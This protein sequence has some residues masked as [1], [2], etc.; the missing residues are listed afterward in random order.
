M[1]PAR[2]ISW[3]LEELGARAAIAEERDR[4]ADERMDRLEKKIDQMLQA[5]A[6]GKG[7]WWAITKLGGI[8]VM[9]IMAGGWAADHFGWWKR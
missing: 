1:T 9:L 5:A 6:M 7:A 3:K 4:V 8:L 2:G